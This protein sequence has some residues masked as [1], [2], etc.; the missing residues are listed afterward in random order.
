M[1]LVFFLLN[2]L[3]ARAVFSN[4]LKFSGRFGQVFRKIFSHFSIL[5]R[6]CAALQ[7]N[8]FQFCFVSGKFRGGFWPLHLV[9][10]AYLE[11]FSDD[12]PIILGLDAIIWEGIFQGLP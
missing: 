1:G 7:V 3:K 10:Q 11:A 6:F 4:F 9:F 12:S 5:G 8:F 2:N